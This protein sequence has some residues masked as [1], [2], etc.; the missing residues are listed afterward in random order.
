VSTQAIE[1]YADL[2]ITVDNAGFVSIEGETNYEGLIV[3]NSEKYTSKTQS[4]WTL[5]ITKNET[6][7][8]FV[9]SI[10]LPEHSKVSSIYSSGS[11]LI[12]EESGNLVIN[13][14][15]SNKSLSIAIEYQTDKI[16][17]TAGLLGVDILSSVLIVFII[18]LVI[19]FILVFLLFDNKKKPFYSPKKENIHQLELRGLNDR[20]KKII[21]L[22]KESNIALTQTDIQ[23]ELDMP[24]ASV[25]RNIRRL[26][27][28]GLI[29]KEQIGMS[30]LIRLK[31]PN[32]D[33]ESYSA[34]KTINSIFFLSCS[35][36]FR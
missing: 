15:G 9:F 34:E 5:N 32:W 20:Q 24:K 16:F 11:T 4:I 8:D 7:S 23:R 6:F 30:N 1:F 35:G 14:Y 27:L 36:S 12:G 19:C 25:S 29:E 17:D 18:V 28:K 10:I 26:E 2:E 33:V 3:E 22:L 31:K 21:T 13:G